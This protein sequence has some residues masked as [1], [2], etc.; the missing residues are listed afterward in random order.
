MSDE[1]L[2]EVRGWIRDEIY[3]VYE[4]ARDALERIGV[5]VRV[6]REA[7]GLSL[8][9]VS[10]LTGIDRATLSWIERGKKLPKPDELDMI[11]AFVT[12]TPIWRSGQPGSDPT[13]TADP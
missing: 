13:G 9:Q 6:T 11:V 8:A 2:A 3:Q 5:G 10:R 12:G 1:Q 4:I 7:R